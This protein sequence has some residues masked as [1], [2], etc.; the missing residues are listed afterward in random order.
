MFLNYVKDFEMFSLA[1][2]VQKRRDFIVRMCSLYRPV[3]RTSSDFPIDQRLS[4]NSRGI[5][6][7]VVDTFLSF[8]R[9]H[10]RVVFEHT[11]HLLLHKMPNL[12]EASVL[13][14]VPDVLFL[15]G[16]F[17]CQHRECIS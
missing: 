12:S 7:S 4:S 15:E 16:L 6:L 1:Y 3:Y 2:V 8:L 14:K 5:G 13:N 17:E 9:K 11:A 10:A